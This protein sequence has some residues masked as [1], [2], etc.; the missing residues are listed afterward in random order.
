MQASSA[1]LPQLTLVPFD[2]VRDHLPD[3][4]PVTSP[5]DREVNLR[6]R[7]IGA[8]LRRRW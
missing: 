4:T 6:Q 8:Q 7:R 1:P 2:T 3:S 5:E